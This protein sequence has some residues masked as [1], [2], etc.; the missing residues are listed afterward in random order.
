[1]EVV[2]VL[3]PLTS[4]KIQWNFISVPT[5]IACFLSTGTVYDYYCHHQSFEMMIFVANN[6]HLKLAE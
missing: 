6:S 1:M 2:T 3:H 4:L 5:F